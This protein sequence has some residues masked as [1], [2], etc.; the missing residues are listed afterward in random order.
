MTSPSHYPL[1]DPWREATVSAEGL[2]YPNTTDHPVGLSTD[3]YHCSDLIT[4]EGTAS[5]SVHR[6]QQQGLA[7]L[8]RWLPQFKTKKTY[9]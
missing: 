3:G 8:A 5:V 7:A 6:V 4:R 1:G 2:G 9:S